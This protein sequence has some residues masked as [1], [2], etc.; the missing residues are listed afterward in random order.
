[1]L[2]SVLQV[3]RLLGKPPT[4]G[5]PNEKTFLPV[6]LERRTDAVNRPAPGA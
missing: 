2:Q 4:A 3:G 1:M 5:V 6:G